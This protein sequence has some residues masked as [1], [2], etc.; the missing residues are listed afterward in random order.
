MIFRKLGHLRWSDSRAVVSVC[1]LQLRTEARLQELL[2]AGDYAG[3]ISLL[4][5]CQIA[6]VTYR[7]FTCIQ[8]LS[9][10]LQDT[11]VMAEEQLDKTLDQV[12][13][14]VVKFIIELK[15]LSS[16]GLICSIV[17]Q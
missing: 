9:T 10:K 15:Y 7:H 2:S 4:H 8:A 14:S 11:L 5:E 16:Y 12:N 17:T 6:A 13:W 1:L 3:A